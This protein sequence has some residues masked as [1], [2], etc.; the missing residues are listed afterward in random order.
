MVGEFD[1]NGP[2]EAAVYTVVNGQGVWTI[3][4][5]VSP[6]TA[7]F[8]QAGDIPEP[9]DYD[10]VG[11][12]E[13]AVYRPS[14]GQFLVMESNGTTETLNLGV[15]SSP[16]LNSL[17]PVPGAYDNQTYFNDK[18]PE[19][20]E[21]A[22]YD[23]NTGVFIISGPSSVYA[24]SGFL[25]G[26]IPA[27]ADYLGDGSTQPVVF[28][29]STG[30]FIGAGGVVIATFGQAGDIP[31]AAPL[32]Y[33]MPSSDPPPTGSTGTGST[34]TGSTGTGSTGTGSTGTGSTGTG[35]TGT[36]S[37]GTGSTGSG[38]A[39]TG[40]T[41]SGSAG[42]G[43]TGSGSTGSTTSNPPPAQSPGSGVSHPVKV[44]HKKAAKPKPKATHHPKPTVHP[45]KVVK[46][47]A[48]K[49]KV[50][51]TAHH[52][53][54]VIMNATASTHSAKPSTHLVDLALEDIHVNLHRSSSAKKHHG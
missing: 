29:P 24:V 42:T 36:G 5:G 50:K 15:G 14:T 4:S 13:I 21:A 38:S 46:H 52:P 33:R 41:G 1:A 40:S 35:S 27:P 30:Q 8:G 51:V 20:T 26:D 23:P 34:G 16:D 32:S 37:T 19:R 3:A 44:T 18:E 54:K 53:T 17:V 22:V 9:G 10:G 39:G 7:T 45:K 11:H 25:K 49:P 47:P 12:D 6:R 31:L 28:R 43:S 48:P 2:D